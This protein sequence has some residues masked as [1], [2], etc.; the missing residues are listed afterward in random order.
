MKHD[1]EKFKLQQKSNSEQPNIM[2]GQSALEMRSPEMRRKRNGIVTNPKITKSVAMNGH[3]NKISN[4]SLTISPAIWP[5]CLNSF[6]LLVK[7]CCVH[8]APSLQYLALYYSEIA[9]GIVAH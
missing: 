1:L 8:C 4:Y 9:L 6:L 7:V 2:M 5:K 3:F